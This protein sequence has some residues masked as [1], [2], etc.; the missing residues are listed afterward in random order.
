MIKSLKIKNYALLKD[1]FI[2]FK[3]GFTVISGVTGS[4]KSIMLDALSLL[5]GKR[6]ERLTID[7]NVP[8]SIIEGV[9]FIDQSKKSFF[10]SHNI[11]FDEETVIR[12]EIN[13]NGKS[14]AFINDT[15]VLLSVLAIF[16]QRIIEI[17]AQHQSI[18]FKDE[19]AQFT[20]IDN[21]A[22]SDNELFAYKESFKIYNKL[23]SELNIINDS[24][25]LSES[26]LDFLRYQLDELEEANLLAGEKEVL[27][28]KI[29]LLENVEGIAKAVSDSE[30]LFNNEKG[31]ISQVSSIKRKLVD[32]DV[33]GDLSDRIDGILIEVN[34][35]SAE[36]SSI[37]SDLE[38]NPDELSRLNK[39]L[40]L[41]NTLLHKHKKQSVIDLID[42]KDKI[43]HKISVSLSFD[44]QLNNKQIQIDQQYIILGKLVLD[45]NEKRNKVLPEVKRDIELYLRKLGMQFANFEVKID[46]FGSY[47]DLGNTKVQFL[48]SANKGSELQP[49]SKVASGG[50]LSRLMLAIKYISAQSSEVSTLVFDEIDSGV[51]GE[52]AS[53]MGDMM[54]EI[55][56]NNQLISIS[57]LP[58]IASKATQHLKIT[59][60][61]VGS[62]TVS[63]VVELSDQERVKEIAKLLSGKEVTAAA[64]ENAKVLL[65]Q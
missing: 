54:L 21:L 44:K 33:F 59:K 57:H 56:R 48:F 61:V 30:S 37:F 40:D 52:I 32:F 64:L 14:R 10:E 39:R 35:I 26:E 42:Y 29:L 27:E 49:M 2:D 6:V 65:S 51:S 17:H 20:F 3:E 24:G 25:T 41:I 8:K 43:K 34:D 38:A 15:P 36:L 11:D 18:L 1:I 19:I 31:V 63:S 4:G 47:H 16:G 58:Q 55:S 46:P 9:F 7:D 60:S 13:S 22:K 62:H 12:R 28:R 53:L 50:E 23:K 45:L 5:L